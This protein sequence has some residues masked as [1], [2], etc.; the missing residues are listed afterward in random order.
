MTTMMGAK[1]SDYDEYVQIFAKEVEQ[2]K[3]SFK[4]WRFFG[5]KIST[6][7]SSAITTPSSWDQSE[8]SQ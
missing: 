3:S 8:Q 7:S 5:Q 4:T 2:Y 6:T 1:S